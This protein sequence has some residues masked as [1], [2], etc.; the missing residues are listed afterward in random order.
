[1]AN[2][3]TKPPLRRLAF[4]QPTSPEQNRFL[5]SL[6]VDCA[7]CIQ[8]VRLVTFTTLGGIVNTIFC[9]T[10]FSHFSFSSLW[11]ALQLPQTFADFPC[12]GDCCAVEKIKKVKG[13]KESRFERFIRGNGRFTAPRLCFGFCL[14]QKINARLWPVSCCGEACTGFK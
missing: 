3:Q 6:Q 14:A 5:L 1:M 13:A 4:P 8:D 2:T 12:C 7:A 9:L 10:P 11:F